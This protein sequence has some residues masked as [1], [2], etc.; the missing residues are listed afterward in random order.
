ML[1]LISSIKKLNGM[2]MREK[3]SHDLLI[4]FLKSSGWSESIKSTPNEMS[5]EYISSVSFSDG[6]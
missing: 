5:F 1:I 2:K 3:Y 4:N 6:Q